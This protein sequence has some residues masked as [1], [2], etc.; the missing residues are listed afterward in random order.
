MR[1]AW[2]KK[3]T[4]SMAENTKEKQRERLPQ[5]RGQAQGQEVWSGTEIR[6]ELRHPPASRNRS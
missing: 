2:A 4:T 1:E 6:R 3:K 5:D